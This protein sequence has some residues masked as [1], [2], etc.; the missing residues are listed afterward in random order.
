[1]FK[2]S[3]RTDLTK[4]TAFLTVEGGEGVG[5][6]TFAAALAQRIV[7]QGQPVELTREPGGCVTAET[8]RGIF[9]A[10]FDD[11]PLTP[12][13]ELFL[14]AAA[15][16]AHVRYRLWPAR[17]RGDWIICDRYID[18]T[19][20][21]QGTIHGLDSGLIEATVHGAIEGLK[22]DITFLLDTSAE[23]ALARTQR[24]MEVGEMRQQPG[25]SRY[26]IGDLAF[27]QKVRRGFLDRAKLESHRF[28]ILDADE[29]TEALV[30]K[31]WLFLT[32]WQGHEKI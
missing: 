22:P 2:I 18:S 9:A 17:K 24:R 12:A 14:L 21:Y 30:N 3:Q 27:Y 29:P 28:C 6:S 11:E 26:D 31:A 8:I 32:D 16:A 19:F 7:E 10:T 20:V 4:K 1:M 15:R 23:V 5:K 13:T 25:V